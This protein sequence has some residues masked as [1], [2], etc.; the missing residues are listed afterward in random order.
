MT[1][2]TRIVAI[3]DDDDSV[4]SAT[5]SLV[6][7]LGLRTATFVS[8]EEFLGATSLDIGCVISDIQMAGISGLELLANLN[9]RGSP[10]PTIIMTAHATDHVRERAALLGAITLLEKPFPPDALV[11]AL[12]EVYG[13]L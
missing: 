9:R 5:S 13:P 4:R 7:S 2:L 10:P 8:A 11:D 6:R 3:I 12:G 1:P